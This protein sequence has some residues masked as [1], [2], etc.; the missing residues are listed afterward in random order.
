MTEPSDQIAEQIA[1]RGRDALI[2]RL[3]PAFE[4]AAAAHADV[5]QLGPEQIETMVQRA[6]D[7]ADGLQWRRA[8]ASVATEELGISLGEAL[9]HPAVVQAH[10]L[11]GAPSYEESLASL[12][13]LPTRSQA[14]PSQE[15]AP[16]ETEAEVQEPEAPEPDVQEPDVPEAEPEAEVQE[17]AAQEPE[18]GEPGAEEPETAPEAEIPEPEAEIPESEAEMPAPDAEMPELEAD[19]PLPEA[20]EAEPEPEPQLEALPLEED[21]DDP[22]LATYVPPP[23]LQPLPGAEGHPTPQ[24]APALP[25]EPAV[26]DQEPDDPDAEADLGGATA[27]YSAFDDYYDED[28]EEGLRMSVVHLGGIANLEPSE[29]DI[30]LLMSAEGLDI[31]RARNDVLGRLEWDQ[32]KALEVPQPRSRRRMRKP[33]PTHLVIRTL[34]GD[35]SFEVPEVTPAELRQ[36]LAPVIAEHIRRD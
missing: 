33:G 2:A 16:T 32:V 7:R 12:G 36:H 17:P 20:L 26:G 19:G 35:A 23:R 29:Q 25:P 3:R 18:A 27:E 31:I 14:A 6:A 30:E 4:E 8:L 5:L 13:P 1:A 34:R 11:V 24:P 22:L 21:D 15:A 10:D 9:S 28:E